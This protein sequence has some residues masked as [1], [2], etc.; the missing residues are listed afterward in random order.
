M[1]KLAP[2]A[3]F[4]ATVK[5]PV[6]GKDES[7][8]AGFV[9]RALDNQRYLQMLIALGFGKYTRPRRIF[10][11]VRLCIRLRRIVNLADV[12]HEIVADWSGFDL[13][14]SRQALERL[15]LTFPSAGWT[16][17]VA[18]M[19]GRQGARIKN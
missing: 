8:E 9:F 12:L 2:D 7:A 14:Y 15:L 19:E 4:E 1:I 6:P 18:Y 3:N 11:R 16:I 10:E 5:I 13:P 17:L